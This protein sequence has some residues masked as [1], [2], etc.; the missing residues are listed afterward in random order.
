MSFCTALPPPPTQS[1]PSSQALGLDYRSPNTISSGQ[2][3]GVP[4][5]TSDPL[6]SLPAAQPISAVTAAAPSASSSTSASASS[7]PVAPVSSLN[8]LVSLTSPAVKKLLGW[9]VGDDEE[10]WAQKAV[11][12]LV[13]KLK[14]RKGA[15]YHL[16]SSRIV[17][18][19]RHGPFFSMCCSEASNFEVLWSFELSVSASRSAQSMHAETIGLMYAILLYTCVLYTRLPYL[20]D[21]SS[22]RA[23]R[24]RRSAPRRSLS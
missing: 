2:Y 5:H 9:R 15:Y 8:S 19:A 16:V 22:V 18:T 20:C 11:D 6:P 24:P 12:W 4:P 3:A 10:L 1:F 17:S 7:V 14:K 21:G 13:K 23:V